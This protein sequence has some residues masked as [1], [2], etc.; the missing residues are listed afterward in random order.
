MAAIQGMKHPS[1]TINGEIRRLERYVASRKE[2][3]WLIVGRVA[4]VLEAGGTWDMVAK[5]VGMS[6]PGAYSKYAHLVKATQTT[7]AKVNH[8][9]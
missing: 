7:R 1:G 6:K 2:T 8:D 5:A 4:A 9:R 3:E